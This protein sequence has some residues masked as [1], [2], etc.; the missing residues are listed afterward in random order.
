[1][2]LT[3]ASEKALPAGEVKLRAL[4]DW[5]VS[6][7]QQKTEALGPGKS[8]E[9]VFEVKL[10]DKSEAFIPNFVYPLLAEFFTGGIR[11]ALYHGV[12]NVN[13]PLEGRE[14]L[15]SDNWSDVNYPWAIWTGAEYQYLT[16]P[17][18]NQEIRDRIYAYTGDRAPI[19]ALQS[20]DRKGQ[21]KYARYKDLS[22]VEIL[23]DLK[24]RYDVSRL[25]VRRGN[26]YATET[27][28]QII[29]TCSKDGK[30]FSKPMS[31]TPKWEGEIAELKLT[32]PEDSRYVK[33]RFEFPN[34]YGCLDEVW[35]FGK[36]IPGQPVGKI[37]G[38]YPE[39]KQQ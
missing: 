34:Q 33:I 10:P 30:A 23:F 36:L 18:D 26:R 4:M 25:L 32:A 28:N 8:A 6:P 9:F 20:E 19:Y 37:W 3:N 16:K 39:R 38:T 31:F 2:T 12:V 17:K 35:I 7:P 15:L 14:L 1:V 5:K 11:T 27:P 13:V 24:S 22:E 29:V 21:H